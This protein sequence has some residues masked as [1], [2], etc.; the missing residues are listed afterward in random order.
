ML[1]VPRDKGMPKEKDENGDGIASRKRKAVAM[2][3]GNCTDIGNKVDKLADKMDTMLKIVG[4]NFKY[5]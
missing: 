3:C 4:Q 2:G 1:V 5:G